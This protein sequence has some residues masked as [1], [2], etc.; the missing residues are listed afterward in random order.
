MSTGISTLLSQ[1]AERCEPRVAWCSCDER[2]E[3]PE[4]LFWRTSP[5]HSARASPASAR[6]CDPHRQPFH[7]IAAL[8][9]EVMETSAEDT[10]L[11]VDDV[12]EL[13]SPTAQ[14]LGALIGAMPPSVSLAI[15][16]RGPAPFPRRSFGGRRLLV[17]GDDDL[18]LGDAEAVQLLREIGAGLQGSDISRILDQSE[19]WVTGVILGAQSPARSGARRGRESTEVFGYF[20]DELLDRQTPAVSDFL[21]RAGVV[22]F[23]PALAAAVVGNDEAPSS[24]SAWSMGTSS[25]PR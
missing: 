24:S 20:A 14:A 8:T 6:A 16:T 13:P 11:I 4:L 21:L 7:Q 3:G 23:T 18:A 25:A 2:L 5:R 10:L 15:A 12:Q 17:L 22:R 9:N 1:I 19:G